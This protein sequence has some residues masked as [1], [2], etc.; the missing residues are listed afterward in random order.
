MTSLTT[1]T[2]APPTNGRQVPHT[3]HRETPLEPPHRTVKVGV[4]LLT[5]GL[6][7]ASTERPGE[8]AEEGIYPEEIHGVITR[9]SPRPCDPKIWRG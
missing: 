2:I 6:G 1:Y 9:P 3:A 8:Q 7:V 4:D 5:G